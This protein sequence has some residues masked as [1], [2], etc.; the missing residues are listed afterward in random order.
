[1]M[2]NLKKV[3]RRIAASSRNYGTP[4]SLGVTVLFDVGPQKDLQIS[5]L[6]PH[7]DRKVVG[8]RIWNA[9]RLACP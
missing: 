6:N 3:G 8:L 9:K 2:R 7:R 5:D 1:M 4:A